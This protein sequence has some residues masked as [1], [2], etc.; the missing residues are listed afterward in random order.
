M[1]STDK[2]IR[3]IVDLAEGIGAISDDIVSEVLIQEALDT[4][5][6][7]LER[8]AAYMQDQYD[9]NVIDDLSNTNEFGDLDDET[10]VNALEDDY[11][12]NID[13][14]DE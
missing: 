11:F 5:L 3:R 14:D 13:E 7:E 12:D 2:I 8:A 1:N 6:G 10:D 9:I 4:A